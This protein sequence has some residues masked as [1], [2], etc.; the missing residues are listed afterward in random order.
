MNNN[1]TGE[2]IVKKLLAILLCAVAVLSCTSPAFA[3]NNEAHSTDSPMQYKP[4]E[5]D[6]RILQLNTSDKYALRMDDIAFDAKTL[7]SKLSVSTDAYDTMMR[8]FYESQ[9]TTE[10]YKK[11]VYTVSGITAE[12]FPEFFAGAYTNQYLDLVVLLTED[13]ITTSLDVSYAQ[14]AI[15][16]AAGTDNIVFATAQYSYRTLVSLMNEIFQYVE[17][18]R[19]NSDGF[20]IVSYSLDDFNKLM[21]GK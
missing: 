3:A 6:P 8:S 18:G 7:D 11:E 13:S 15:C 14:E 4:F 10:K 20:G 1:R 9:A 16:T 5:T 2:L 17:C 21:Q 12:G 19:N